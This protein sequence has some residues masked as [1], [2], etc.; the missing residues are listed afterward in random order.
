MR[1]LLLTALVL[2]A[3][4]DPL[5]VAKVGSR[6]L[7]KAEVTL[8]V[9][10][11]AKAA[12]L[13]PKDALEALVERELFAEGARRAGLHHDEAVRARLAQLEREVLA[14]AL[15]EKEAAS[16]DEAALKK[17]Y[18]EKKPS[19]EVREVHVAQIFVSV[20]QGATAEERR[21]HE[22]RVAA[23]HA[24]L[25]GGDDFAAV[26]R[27]ASDDKP[28]AE[29][30]GDVGR[31]REGQVNQDFFAAAAALKAGE[32]S[33]PVKTEHGYHLLKAL[34]APVTVVPA[35]DELRGRLLADARR[36]LEE[37]LKKKLEAEITV[38]RYPAALSGG[39]P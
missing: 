27:E 2:A 35:F 4:T 32:L 18:E 3:C 34:E 31:V 17:R 16:L 9:A 39:A 19:L 11:K 25:V 10:S 28:S 15:L 33:K 13:D 29:R 38:K 12:A 30:G 14:Q 6:E 26:A 1:A 36:E 24:R 37:S 21:Q 7:R 5:V 23:I 20:P 22:S 8:L